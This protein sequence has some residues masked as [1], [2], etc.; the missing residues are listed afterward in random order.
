MDKIENE[1]QV[2]NDLD[3]WIAKLKGVTKVNVDALI[4]QL[5]EK[6]EIIDTL[7]SQSDEFANEVSSLSKAL[8][9]E[10]TRRSSQAGL[11]WEV[12]G[13][14]TGLGRPT[15]RLPCFGSTKM[16]PT[17]IFCF[18]KFFIILNQTRFS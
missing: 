9:E 14:Q 11:L 18:W 6:E 7:E 13:L 12:A 2:T 10:Q 17:A 15:G 3:A 1:S 8:E 5:D 4:K 16:P